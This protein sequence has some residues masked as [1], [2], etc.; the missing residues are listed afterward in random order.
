MSSDAG[1]MALF[2]TDE[3]PPQR[4]LLKA[5]K[6]TAV[7]E[8]GNL[9]T[10]RFGGV[11]VLRAV[12]YLARDTSW[13]TYQAELSELQV[14]EDEKAFRV[15]YRGLCAGPEGRFAYRM[16]MNGDASGH[17]TL[18]AAGEG[19]TDFPTNRT[20]FV[21]LHP[22]EAA[23]IELTVRH[24]DGT[25]EKTVF[26]E[27]ISPDQPV[28]DITAMT[29]EPAPGLICLV[30]LE[31]D[32]FEMEDQRNW[33][34]ASFKT[35]I[36]PLSKLRPYVIGRGVQ[37]MQHVTL[38]MEGRPPAPARTSSGS[39]ARLSLGASTGHIPTLAL[40]LESGDLPPAGVVAH[41][42]ARE[43]IVRFDPARGDD[44][45]MLGRAAGFAA[46]IGAAPAIEIV[47]DARNP[48]NEAAVAM[49][50]IGE[51][52]VDAAALLVSPRR[53]FTTRP[54]NTLP[55]GEHP[56]AALVDALREAGASAPIGAGTPSNF[57]E[58]NRNPP[59]A[60]CDFVFFGVSGVVH[61]A[62]D[63]SVMETLGVYP[64]LAESA[65]RLCPGRAI[66]LGPCTIGVRHNPYG[67]GVVPNPNGRRVPSA[68]VDPRQGAL[69]G[70][71]F[72][73]G[74]AAQAASAGVE[75]LV[76]AAPSGPFG[77]VDDR[78]RPR[79][80]HGV[81]AELAAAAGSERLAADPDRPGIAALAWRNGPAARV[82]VAN[83]TPDDIDLELPAGVKTVSLVDPDAVFRDCPFG[84]G[85]LRLPAYR[86]ARIAV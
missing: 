27:A 78:G 16:E 75:R 59:R 32:A 85:V 2:G 62:D 31:G 53:E 11:E 19:L 52:G 50:A 12:N 30:E 48:A 6:L 45:A 42:I 38:H 37:D 86:V 46:S 10:I 76:L 8:D 14:E 82:L 44:A 43:V 7:L 64:A 36:R 21:L 57:T 40:F 60:E 56:V 58:F 55:E 81:H 9:R 18:E 70:A 34:D 33:A 51:A 13:G 54:S 66:W 29:H 41:G 17:L 68:R 1:S 3:P 28:F 74:V 26:P 77:L 20:G 35:Y 25:T 80:F 49:R 39:V 47:F 79:P 4:R 71:A 22:A 84:G 61:A 5:G 67:A 83:L 73:V 65:R 23:G 72:A 15:S 69:F 24:A 63:L